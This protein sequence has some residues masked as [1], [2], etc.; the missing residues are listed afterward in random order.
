[1]SD[2]PIVTRSLELGSEMRGSQGERDL[3]TSPRREWD[4]AWMARK[5]ATQARQTRPIFTPL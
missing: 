2:A 3:P 5:I 1:L 4:I